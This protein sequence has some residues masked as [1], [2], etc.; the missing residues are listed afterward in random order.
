M[1]HLMKMLVFR[2]ERE[3]AMTYVMTHVP[4][5]RQFSIWKRECEV[6]GELNN[7]ISKGE[8]PSLPF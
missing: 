8:K 2:V 7:L 1:T 3:Y 6:V 4:E 5:G